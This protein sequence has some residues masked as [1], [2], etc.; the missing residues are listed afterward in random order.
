MGR[1][2]TLLPAPPGLGTFFS[3]P[4]LTSAVA[5]STLRPPFVGAALHHCTN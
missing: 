4:F 1:L 5:V 3:R 2:S